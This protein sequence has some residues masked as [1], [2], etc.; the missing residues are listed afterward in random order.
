[1][2]SSQ[3]G[4]KECGAAR[5]ERRRVEQDK[6]GRGATQTR[7][8]GGRHARTQK[9]EKGKDK[10]I[11]RG[12]ETTWGRAFLTWPA[13]PPCS[14]LVLSLFACPVQGHQSRV[15]GLWVEPPNPRGFSHS[16]KFCIAACEAAI[17]GSAKGPGVT[18]CASHQQPYSSFLFP[19][20]H[21]R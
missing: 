17:G 5:Q 15:S 14:V 13:P 6:N 2:P 1:M 7:R 21:L 19:K 16:R 10:E 9:S 18:G 8:R 4:Q 20:M 11:T 3:A 12:E